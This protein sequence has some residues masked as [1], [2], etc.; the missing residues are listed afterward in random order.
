MLI[1][2]FLKAELYTTDLV[3]RKSCCSDWGDAPEAGAAQTEP[4]FLP[5]KVHT[6]YREGLAQIGRNRLQPPLS[7]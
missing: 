1:V 3:A 6:F 5:S 2:I 7:R 4:S